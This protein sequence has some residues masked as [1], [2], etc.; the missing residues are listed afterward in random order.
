M[1]CVP[2]GPSPA[3]PSQSAINVVLASPRATALCSIHSWTSARR[4]ISACFAA[5]RATRRLL[6]FAGGRG[7]VLMVEARNPAG[8]R[9]RDRGRHILIARNDQVQAALD[10]ELL[11]NFMEKQIAAAGAPRDRHDGRRIGRNF[12]LSPLPESP[13]G[14]LAP[15]RPGSAATDGSDRRC[16]VR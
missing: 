2:P 15:W 3:L 13:L 7:V 10:P 16:D 4:R 1:C 8:A 6:I 11:A 9:R 14:R 12:L 5:T